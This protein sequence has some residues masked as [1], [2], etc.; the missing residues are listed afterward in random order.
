MDLKVGDVFA[1]KYVIWDLP[2]DVGG[3]GRVLFVHPQGAPQNKLALKF[4]KDPALYD[5]FKRE[6]SILRKYAG[7]TKVIQILD[8][9]LDSRPPFFTM[10]YCAKGDVHSRLDRVKGDQAFQEKVF[11]RLI[12]AVAELHANGDVHRDLKPQNFLILDDGSVVV[13]DFGLAKLGDGGTVLTKTY[14][15]GGTHEFAPPEFYTEG[16]FKNATIAWDIFS[17]GKTF[18]RL[19]SGRNALYISADGLPPSLFHVIRKSCEIDPKLRYKSLTELRQAV[20]SAFDIILSRL[21]PGGQ[22]IRTLE[23]TTKKLGQ[24]RFNSDEVRE[25]LNTLPTLDD[26]TQIYFAENLPNHFLGIVGSNP[27]FAKSAESV[28]EAYEKMLAQKEMRN[29]G[30]SYA[31]T[32]AADMAELFQ[33][34]HIENTL[35]V[36]CLRIAIDWSIRC[37]RFAAMDK[38]GDMIKSVD[39][40]DLGFLVADLISEFYEHGFISSIEATACK[41]A[42]IRKK[43]IELKAQETD[44]E[45]DFF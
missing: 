36:R 4:C 9:K 3:M 45:E 44:A 15:Q 42:S 38:C 37:N 21:E 26:A 14:D 28:V 22:F 2:P 5:R 13:S 31:E 34:P 27:D 16:G 33:S 19:A 20:Q 43:L 10:P 18:Y 11:Y 29:V 17:L 23:I 40:E 24:G 41:S 12:D 8:H 7:N 1:D 25:L 39:S 32:V 35:R 30:F 6:V